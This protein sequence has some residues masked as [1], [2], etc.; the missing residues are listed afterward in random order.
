[1]LL[2]DVEVE[3]GTAPTEIYT[4]YDIVELH[5]EKYIH[6]LSR[7]FHVPYSEK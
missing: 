3:V 5:N 4:V 1:M 6:S 7:T 2:C